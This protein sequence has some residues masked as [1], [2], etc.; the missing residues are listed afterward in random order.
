VAAVALHAG[1][2]VEPHLVGEH[3]A[4]GIEVARVEAVDIGREQRTIGFGEDGKRMIV[5][6]LRQLAQPR[7]TTV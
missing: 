3:V 2:D 7:A 6:F 5:G 1:D 4:D